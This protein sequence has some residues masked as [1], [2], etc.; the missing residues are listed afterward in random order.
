MNTVT[1]SSTKTKT[2]EKGKMGTPENSSVKT[3]IN[4]KRLKKNANKKRSKVKDKENKKATKAK[5]E[6]KDARTDNKSAGKNV[7]KATSLKSNEVTTNTQ[8][9]KRKRPQSKIETGKQLSGCSPV[10]G[11]LPAALLKSKVREHFS[12]GAATN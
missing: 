1:M 6:N 4:V 11:E 12:P 8:S 7:V 3:S 9:G 10:R 2:T 5:F